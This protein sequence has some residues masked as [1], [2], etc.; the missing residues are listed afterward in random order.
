MKLQTVK[1][2]MNVMYALCLALIAAAILGAKS[3]LA[4][5]FIGAAAVVAVTLTLFRLKFWRCPKCGHMLS[6]GSGTRCDFC[7]WEMRL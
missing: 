5:V 4:Y 1:T 7:K 6:K 3:G 2:A